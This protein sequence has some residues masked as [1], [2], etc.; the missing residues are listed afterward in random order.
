MITTVE[1][2]VR[3]NKVV[4]YV[5]IT[6]LKTAKE[7]YVYNQKTYTHSEYRTEIDNF[8]DENNLESFYM[9]HQPI[10]KDNG[11]VI[12]KIEIFSIDSEK[13]EKEIV[14]FKEYF[15]TFLTII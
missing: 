6:T 14:K 8:I 13:L 12:S 1:P 5:F 4:G 9:Q 3:E 7:M 10:F 15:N 2:T 11:N